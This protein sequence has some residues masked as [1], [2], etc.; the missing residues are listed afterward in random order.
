ML[1]GNFLLLI[2]SAQNI[3]RSKWEGYQFSIPSSNLD[4]GARLFEQVRFMHERDHQTHFLPTEFISKLTTNVFVSHVTCYTSA[5]WGRE[6]HD[7]YMLHV[8]RSGD[9]ICDWWS[10][11]RWLRTL[12][13]LTTLEL[14]SYSNIWSLTSHIRLSVF[15][16]STDHMFM[17]ISQFT[18]YL[19]V[20]R[21]VFPDSV[22]RSHCASPLLYTRSALQA[23]WP[24]VVCPAHSGPGRNSQPAQSN[25]P[26]EL[27]RLGDIPWW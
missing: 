9:V 24:A 16:F 14:N 1:K 7:C 15:M 13:L 19:L 10:W 2:S 12:T 5:V 25:S 23:T 20:T 21:P 3:C 27:A 11:C 18:L 22:S 26:A 17:F 6:S 4:W 8:M